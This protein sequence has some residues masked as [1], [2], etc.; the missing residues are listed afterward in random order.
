MSKEMIK[1]TPTFIE[2]LRDDEGNEVEGHF[3][4]KRGIMLYKPEQHKWVKIG[5]T[6]THRGIAREVTA[7]ATDAFSFTITSPDTFVPEERWFVTLGPL[8][9]ASDK[10]EQG[11]W[12][13]YSDVSLKL[14]E[15]LD[16]GDENKWNLDG[17]LGAVKDNA[18]MLRA[19]HR[20]LNELCGWGDE[21]FLHAYAHIG[22]FIKNLRADFRAERMLR[23][24]AEADYAFMVKKAADQS[25]EGYRE[26]GA[27]CAQLEAEADEL[28]RQISELKNDST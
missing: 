4:F 23:E 3:C 18:T 20:E 28:R 16:P 10:F 22:N 24:K 15:I 2:P 11:R 27:R 7:G 12:E 9:A 14:R 8:K 17:L 19:M 25:L 6:L 26:L 21:S 13:G 1:L 5:S